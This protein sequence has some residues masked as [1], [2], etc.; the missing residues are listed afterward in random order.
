MRFIDRIRCERGMTLM[1]LLVSA[2]ICAVGV[3]ATIAVFDT[4]RE[5]S[6]KAELRE[7]MSHQAQREL[8]RVMEFPYSEFAHTTAPLSS[9]TAGNPANYVSGSTYR[10]D[11]KVPTASEP[12]A[13]DAAGL[14]PSTSTTWQ[15]GQ[16]RLSGRVYRFVT[17]V[18]TNARRVTIVVTG[19]GVKAPTPVLL[20]SIKTTPSLG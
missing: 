16:L 3:M 8:E 2:T 10:Y 4:S 13:I 11:R 5:V 15:D 7:Q 14:V 1:E 17:Q 19:D 12:F 20:S 18:S 6:V 9:P